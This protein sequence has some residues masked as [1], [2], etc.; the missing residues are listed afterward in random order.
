MFKFTEIQT[1]RQ[2]SEVEVNQINFIPCST[3]IEQVEQQIP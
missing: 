3:Q 2:L 1:R